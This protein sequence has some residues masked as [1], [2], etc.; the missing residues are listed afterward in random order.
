VTSR[1]RLALLLLALSALILV[2]LG[3]GAVDPSRSAR[4][5]AIDMRVSAGSAAQ[6]YWS[7]DSQFV[8]AR[9]SRVPLH[10]GADGFE[11]LRFPLAASR[12]LRFDPTDAPAEIRIARIQLLD[13]ADEVIE[14]IDPRNFRPANQIAAVIREGELTRIVTTPDG[15]D[16]FLILSL[17]LPAR[18]EGWNT[19]AAVTPV[20]LMAVSILVLALL[21]AC[22]SEIGRVARVDERAGAAPPASQ[23]SG[24][25]AAVTFLS[26]FLIVFSAKL[27]T[28][29]DSPAVTPFWDQWDGEAAALFVPFSESTLSWK[30]MV[31]LHNEHRIFFTRLLALDL[32]Q[33]NGQWDPRLEAVTNAAIHSLTAVLLTVMF[34]V[35]GGRRHLELLA[36]VCGLVFVPPFAWENVLFGFQNAFYFVLL[37]SLLALWLTTSSP[38]NRL[39]WWLGWIC[40]VCALFTAATG[41]IVPVAILGVVALKWVTDIREWRPAAA[42]ALAAAVVLAMAFAVASPPLPHHEYLKAKTMAEFMGALRQNLAWPWIDQPAM[43]AVMWLPMIVLLGRAAIARLQTTERE[44]LLAGLAGW[45]VI[46]AGALAYG[47]GAGAGPPATRYMDFLSI[48]FVINAVALVSLFE[49]T[50]AGTRVRRFVMVLL[51]AWISVATVGVDRLAGNMSAL[52]SAWRPFFSAHAANSRQFV[53]TGDPATVLSKHGPA[54]IPYPDA[55]QLVQLLQRPSI[56]AILPAAVRQPLRIEPRS[57][58][59]KG[60]VVGGPF[61]GSIPQDPLQIAWWSL[62]GEGRRAKGRFESEPLQCQTRGLLRFEVS[63]YL[64]WEH[65]YLALRDLESR[66]DVAIQPSQVARESWTGVVVP[67]PPGRFTIV[68]IDDS[69]ESWFGFREPVEIAALSTAAEFVIKSSREMLIAFLAMA[70]VGLALRSRS[71]TRS[72]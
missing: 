43:W 20:S 32:L 39:A 62:S 19:V 63:G 4:A 70:A 15:T 37:F 21:A 47:R 57:V 27:L 30:T 7:D 66:R 45:V 52:L 51:F 29:K 55:N 5:I 8:E 61:A 38:V 68:A 26:L 3:G 22:L 46:S 31:A 44:R 42:N 49:C 50:Q 64:G 1:T 69:A 34:W 65:Q 48:G 14:A 11:R 16:P 18:G 41:A 40:A 2:S 23:A 28:M 6:I 58:T 25:S 67:C 17:G 59:S 33:I 36:V 13:A 71:P 56:R 72:S 54:E 9:S 53:L 10:P 60:F 24:G 35:P 12:S